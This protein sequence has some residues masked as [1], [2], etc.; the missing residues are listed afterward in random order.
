ME[1]IE[2]QFFN[3][4]DGFLSKKNE[5]NDTSDY[6]WKTYSGQFNLVMTIIIW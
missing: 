2:F 3:R 5:K 1:K 4:S 6:K